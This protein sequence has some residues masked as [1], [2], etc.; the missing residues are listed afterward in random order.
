MPRPR[1]GRVSNGSEPS[2]THLFGSNGHETLQL[3]EFHPTRRNAQH[4]G[5]RLLSEPL[6]LCLGRLTLPTSWWCKT[7][8][9]L[10]FLATKGAVTVPR[11]ALPFCQG[12][13][14]ALVASSARLCERHGA[15][16]CGCPLNA[17]KGSVDIPPD[18]S[19]PDRNTPLSG[20]EQCAGYS[21]SGVR[22][23]QHAMSVQVIPAGCAICQARVA[24][25]RSERAR[26]R[27][28]KPENLLLIL[29]IVMCL[30]ISPTNDATPPCFSSFE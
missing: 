9:P 19:G 6:N 12:V 14:L 21:V 10:V 13:D 20:V 7:R 18:A 8:S 1:L 16:W 23:A 26:I 4:A 2:A 3:V 11:I 27:E 24:S 28:Q 15:C 5:C 22:G 30:S 25:T 17:K 29:G